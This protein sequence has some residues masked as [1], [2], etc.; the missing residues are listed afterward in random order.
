MRLNLF[1]IDPASAIQLTAAIAKKYGAEVGVRRHC[2]G[3]SVIVSSSELF[4]REA[5]SCLY[6][7]AFLA[8]NPAK[9][10][11]ET[12]AQRKET[13]TFAESCTGGA[14]AA[15]FVSVAGASSVLEGSLVTYS[16]RLKQAWLGVDGATLERFGAVSEPC[17]LQMATGAI[18]RTGATRALAISGIAGPNGGTIAKPVGTV[19]VGYADAGV[20]FA[21]ELRLVGSRQAVQRQAVFNAMRLLIAR[22]LRA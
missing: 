10:A 17:V 15:R 8:D 16:N 20:Q 22:L 21:E 14:L 19:F 5:E 7:M 9:W 6:P 13:I 4:L 18:A 1:G 12:L 2:G 11:V 3:W